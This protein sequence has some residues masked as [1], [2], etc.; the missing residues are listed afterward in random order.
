[1]GREEQ[2][3]SVARP[4][5][6]AVL[7]AAK[8]S[9]VPGVTIAEASKRFGVAVSAVQRARRSG[10]APDLS[11]AELALAALTDNGTRTSGRLD[12]LARIASWLDYVNHDASTV[13]D[14]V[15][16]LATLPDLLVI[17][18]DTWQL[19]GAWP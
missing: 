10:A 14:V 16:L 13:D 12:G 8:L 5:D 3:L 19:V 2:A 11:L 1:M 4:F 18:G 7:R 9:R 6:P 15:R 17:E